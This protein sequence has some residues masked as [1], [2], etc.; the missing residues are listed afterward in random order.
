VQTCSTSR[1]L[2]I[3]RLVAGSSSTPGRAAVLCCLCAA[4]VQSDTQ[5]RAWALDTA[6]LPVQRKL[7]PCLRLTRAI[8]DV[9]LVVCVCLVASYDPSTMHS[10][11]ARRVPRV[12]DCDARYRVHCNLMR[13]GFCNIMWDS[14]TPA[15]RRG[16]EPSGDW[17]TNGCNMCS[18]F[19]TRLRW[20]FPTA[21]VHTIHIL[22]PSYWR[23]LHCV[24][25]LPQHSQCVE[26]G[27]EARGRTLRLEARPWL[28]STVRQVPVY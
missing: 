12:K 9:P 6:L 16:S 24:C 8:A 28:G 22:L 15:T 13:A 7:C 25:A 11:T 2:P 17:L 1:R 14:T 27:L 21:H 20:Q 4:L 18:T 3:A 19:Q 10:C 23:L 5:A 26:R